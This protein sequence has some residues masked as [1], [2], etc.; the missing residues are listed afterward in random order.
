MIARRTRFRKHPVLWLGALL[1][2]GLA[3]CAPVGPA[4]GPAPGPASGASVPVAL[5]VPGGA[6]DDGNRVLARSL[7]NAARMA[8]GDLSGAEIDLRV[9]DTAAD[10]GRAGEV[11]RQAVDE[12]ARVILGPVYSRS[13]VAAAEAVA[14]RGVNVLSF[15]N[16]TTIAGENLFVMGRTFANV[17]RRLAGFAAGQGIDRVAIVPDPTD[18]GRLGAEAIRQAVSETGGDV[19]AA[20]SYT[21]SQQGVVEAAPRIAEAV[22]SADAQALF[23]TADS[24]GALPLLA[25]LLPENGVAPEDVQY[26]GLARWDVPASTLALAGLQGGWFALPDPDLTARFRARYEGRFGAPPHPIA[27]LAYDGVAAI[28][29]LAASQGAGAAA[30]RAGLTQP[31]GFAG[32]AG[33]FRLRP[34]GTNRR[35]LAVAEVQDGAAVVISPAP[36]GFGGSAGF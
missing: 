16:D 1:V 36:R 14:G 35:A 11:A 13:A 22:R 24:A 4:G 8:A 20:S 21:F 23:L 33:V 27:A 34:D 6:G 30:S 31:S 29:A 12:G 15:S 3:A 17:A 7:E 9:Y 26:I 10:A 19:V 18:S 2:A 25:Q 28:G 32:A 5:L